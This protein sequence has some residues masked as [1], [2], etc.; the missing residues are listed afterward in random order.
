[1]ALDLTRHMLQGQMAQ[2]RLCGAT[3]ALALYEQ[4]EIALCKKREELAKEVQKD[5]PRVTVH[6]AH[7]IPKNP[8]PKLIR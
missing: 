5:A 3:H 2:M 4:F 7:E 1:M 8:P 6:G